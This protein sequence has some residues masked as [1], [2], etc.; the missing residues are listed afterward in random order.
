MISSI[1]IAAKPTDATQRKAFLVGLS[2]AITGAILFSTKAI[3]LLIAAT[4]L[5]KRVSRVEW[6]ALATSYLGIVLVFLHDLKAGGSNV[7]LGALFVLA[8]AASYAL[9]LIFSGELVKRIG[10]TRLVA[11]AM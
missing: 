4:F 5:K 9:Y 3:V 10:S 2:I 11:Y 1:S 8:A 6:L 7:A